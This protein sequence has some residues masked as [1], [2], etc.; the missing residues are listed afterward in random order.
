[1]GTDTIRVV[2]ELNVAG[3]SSVGVFAG[4]GLTY[5]TLNP[6]VQQSLAY[7]AEAGVPTHRLD[8][9]MQV[10]VQI[11][12]LLD[13]LLG[14]AA[15]DTV[16]I[17]H[18]AAGYGWSTGVGRNGVNLFSTVTHEFGHVLGLRHH[19]SNDVMDATLALDNRHVVSSGSETETHGLDSLTSEFSV[20]DFA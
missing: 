20:S 6:I 19:D 5:A 7:W 10:N 12:D 9:L 2:A 13:P 11:P 8:A 3:T 14:L 16:W 1:M 4:D 18:H 17:D 15:L